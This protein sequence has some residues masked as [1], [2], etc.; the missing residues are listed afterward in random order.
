MTPIPPPDPDSPEIRE[1][2]PGSPDSPLETPIDTPQ[3][4]PERR[5]PDWHPPGTDDAP[6]RMPGEHPDPEAVL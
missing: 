4:V 3:E 5:E 1:P 6:M 2:L